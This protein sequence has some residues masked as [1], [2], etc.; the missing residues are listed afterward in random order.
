ML[1]YKVTF[2]HVDSNVFQMT[3]ASALFAP[4]EAV[5]LCTRGYCSI[6]SVPQAA[7]HSGWSLLGNAGSAHFVKVIPEKDKVR[8]QHCKSGDAKGILST[9]CSTT[10]L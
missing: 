5:F 10:L 4:P 2:A 1:L 6:F 8:C 3:C 9:P 7:P